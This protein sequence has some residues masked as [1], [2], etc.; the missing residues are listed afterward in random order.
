MYDGLM[1]R[2][3][4]ELR[5]QGPTGVS[6]RRTRISDTE[7]EER[8]IQA[9][10]DLVADAGLTV[11]L[12]HL[13]LETVIARADVSR[14]S[15]YRRWPFKDLFLADLLVA[16]ARHTDLSAEPPGLVDDLKALIVAA[17]LTSTESRRDVLIEAL[18]LSSGTEFERLWASPRWRTYIALSATVTG[19]PAGP[20]RDA[21]SAAI[22]DAERRFAE[23]RGGVFRNLARMIGY[24]PRG[25]EPDTGFELMASASGAVMTG[26]IVRALVNEDLVTAAR[27]LAAFG[28][29]QVA[30]WTVPAYGLTA[31]F[32]AFLEPDPDASWSPEALADRRR[33]WEQTA[34]S[35]YEV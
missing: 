7:T 11:S 10:L 3:T 15:A 12:D 25:L 33:L 30:D 34:D 29:R 20:I 24:R 27:P 14:S 22:L 16:V 21:A 4:Q 9:A 5:H 35:L 32:D 28:S 23:R 18:R 31:V 2:T 26:Y 17:D 13:S 1:V 8:M 6:R 19:L